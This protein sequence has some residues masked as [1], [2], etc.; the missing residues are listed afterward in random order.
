MFIL[1]NVLLFKIVYIIY[2]NKFLIKLHA[3]VKK[4]KYYNYKH[5]INGGKSDRCSLIFCK[6]TT[7]TLR[8][9]WCRDTT[10]PCFQIFSSNNSLA[11]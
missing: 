10:G 3:F 5:A 9:S 8:L 6:V 2:Y 7:M 4:L 1:K 11:Y